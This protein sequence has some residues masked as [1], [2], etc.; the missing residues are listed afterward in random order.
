VA[1]VLGLQLRHLEIVGLVQPFLLLLRL[2]VVGV[3]QE[4]M[5][6]MC[7]LLL[8]GLEA[9]VLGTLLLRR[10]E[11]QEIPLIHLHLKEITAEQV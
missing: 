10:Q 7:N 11:L 1:A 9:V 6:V 4:T 5:S 8:V 2:V 3:D